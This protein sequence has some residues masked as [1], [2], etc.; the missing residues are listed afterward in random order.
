MIDQLAL[1]ALLTSG[2]YDRHLRRMRAVYAARRA[3]LTQ[4]FA[5]HLPGV[6]LTGLAAGFH[7]VAP[8]GRRRGRDGIGTMHR[9]PQP[10]MARSVLPCAG[11][12]S[13]VAE[14][15]VRVEAEL[16]RLRAQNARLLKLLRLSPQQTASPAPGQAGFF[17]ASPG[18]V[19]SRSPQEAKVAF[20]GALFAAQTDVYAV[21]Y[22]NQR[23]GKSEWVPAVRG[24]WMRRYCPTRSPGLATALRCVAGRPEA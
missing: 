6:G 3:A 10:E 14:D 18:V 15:P 17:E 7:A 24:G 21:R 8:P 11:S 13:L 9:G 5:R 20:F 19:H 23:T 2:R 16:A 22:D 12:V 4:A 1:A